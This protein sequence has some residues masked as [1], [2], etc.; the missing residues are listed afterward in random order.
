[1]GLMQVMPGTYEQMRQRYGLGA[2]PYDPHDNVLAGAAYLHALHARYGNPGM[3]AAY[4][5]GP[6]NFHD[7]IRHGRP[8]PPETRN[9]LHRIVVALKDRFEKGPVL[10]VNSRVLVID[11]S[12]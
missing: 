12:G 4:N 7:H 2:D 11:A 5:A 10:T 9:Y 3:F 1:M 6:R 8:L